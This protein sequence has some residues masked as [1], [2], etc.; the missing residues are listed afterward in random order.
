MGIRRLFGTLQYIQ[1]LYPKDDEELNKVRRDHLLR[2]Y[3][4]SR[5]QNPKRQIGSLE[6]PLHYSVKGGHEKLVEMFC[7]F[8][9]CDKNATTKDGE[10]PIHMAARC[11]HEKIVEL[12]ASFPDVDVFRLL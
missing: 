7:S 12:L 4:Q 1:R 8:A 3:F 5:T 6:V 2:A 11:G 10:T 9:Q